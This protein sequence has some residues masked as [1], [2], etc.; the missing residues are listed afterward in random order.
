[1]LA[2]DPLLCASKA[3]CNTLCADTNAAADN[4]VQG[5]AER[6]VR[7]VRVGNPAKVR[8]CIFGGGVGLQRCTRGTWGAFVGR[9]AN[10]FVCVCV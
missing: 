7:V 3:A 10:L 5:L 1:M 9:P 2:I 4:L 6:G 8:S